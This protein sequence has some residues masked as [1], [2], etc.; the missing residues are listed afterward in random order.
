MDWSDIL[1]YLV[2]FLSMFPMA[3]GAVVGSGVD[4]G[5]SGGDT[6]GGLSPADSSD[7]YGSRLIPEDAPLFEGEKET[8]ETK[9]KKPKAKAKA[10]P[11]RQMVPGTTDDFEPGEGQV[12]RKTDTQGDQ[13]TSTKTTTAESPISDIEALFADEL[14]TPKKPETEEVED[15]PEGVEPDSRFGRRFQALLDER[16]SFAAREQEAATSAW[17]HYNH[18][19]EIRDKATQAISALQAQVAALNAKVETADSFRRQADDAGL[20]PEE[21]LRREWMGSLND[22]MNKRTAEATQPLQQKL[23]QV[24]QALGQQREDA[25]LYRAKQ[26]L[27]AE[28][29]QAISDVL[30][31]GISDESIDEVRPHLKR[32]TYAI[33]ND[34][35]N[36]GHKVSMADAA[37]IMRRV[38]LRMGLGY[39]RGKSL[40]NKEQQQRTS[41]VPKKL[42]PAGPHAAGFEGDPSHALVTFNGYQDVAEW[43]M[44]GRP[45]LK[46]L[47]KE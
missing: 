7:P 6:D 40:Q 8:K 34:M 36:A 28:V 20:S 10:K 37:G 41:Q 19:N 31:N 12:L 38:A 23:N 45:P 30:L 46:P 5:D 22:E 17:Q 44:A 39:I 2:T 47:P 4:S 27:G 14:G 29:D 33:A 43:D 3:F 18:A 32:W 25:N 1:V 13:T 21:K 15:L 11:E 35:Y 9:T 26:R 16:K 24:I 42:P